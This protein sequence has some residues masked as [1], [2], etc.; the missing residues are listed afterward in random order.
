MWN[1]FKWI[2]NLWFFTK[3]YSLRN[4]CPRCWGNWILPTQRPPSLAHL[5]HVVLSILPSYH[6]MSNSPCC[7]FKA[8]LHFVLTLETAS[9]TGFPA[10]TY[11]YTSSFSTLSPKLSLKSIT[12]SCRFLLHLFVNL[13]T[14]CTIR[15][16]L[17]AWHHW[18]FVIWMLCIALDMPMSPL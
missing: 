6:P 8:A 14:D 3:D 12:W 15:S 17:P 7:C 5:L 18:P 10:L 13:L 2:D 1:P 16:N 9:R 4:V 11:H